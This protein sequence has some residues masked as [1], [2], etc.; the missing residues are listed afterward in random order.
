MRVALLGRFDGAAAA[1][2]RAA[3]HRVVIDPA[4]GPVSTPAEGADV[5]V[6]SLPDEPAVRRVY[7]ELART[8]APGQVFADLSEVSA[9]TRAWCALALPAFVAVGGDGDVSAEPAHG[10]RARPVLEALIGPVRLR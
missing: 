4:T 2:L 5:V 10:E 8:A 6:T 9:A 1:R 7:S 3:G